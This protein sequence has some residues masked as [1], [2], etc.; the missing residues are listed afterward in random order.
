MQ[1]ASLELVH[2]EALAALVGV[3]L[4]FSTASNRNRKLARNFL[5]GNRALHWVNRKA[6]EAD[7]GTQKVGQQAATMA[8]SSKIVSAVMFPQH[9]RM[10]ATAH[11]ALTLSENMPAARE[12]GTSRL[13]T[14]ACV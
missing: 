2:R 10:A 6:G 7:M 9:S 13:R 1:V 11:M 3:S 12:S 14:P 8:C 4:E 5:E